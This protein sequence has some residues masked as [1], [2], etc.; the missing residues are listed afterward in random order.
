MCSLQVPSFDSTESSRHRCKYVMVVIKHS[1]ISWM[2]I[3]FFFPPRNKQRMH[4]ALKS[5][6]QEAQN[7]LK[8]FKVSN[9]ICLCLALFFFFP[10]LN[11]LTSAPEQSRYCLIGTIT[12]G[13]WSRRE[14]KNLLLDFKLGQVNKSFPEL[15]ICSESQRNN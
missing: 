7:N 4:F 9:Q 14:W 10:W 3:C 8:I 11:N 6:L 5:L 1:W 12:N 15:I 2:F 13:P